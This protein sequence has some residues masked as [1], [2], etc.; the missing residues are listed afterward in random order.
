MSNKD[1]CITGN[2]ITQKIIN[3]ESGSILIN[4]KLSI[5]GDTA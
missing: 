1:A 2:T 3:H 4:K 5:T